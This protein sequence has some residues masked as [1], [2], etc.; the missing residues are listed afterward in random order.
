MVQISR[1]W[2]RWRPWEPGLA[3]LDCS[4][5]LLGSGSRCQTQGLEL[6]D[7]GPA[8]VLAFD[9]WPVISEVNVVM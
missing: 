2:G 4:P 6:D 7:D 9:R 1:R 8:L 5:P 3:W